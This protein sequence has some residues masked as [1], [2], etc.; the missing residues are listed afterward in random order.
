MDPHKKQLHASLAYQF[1]AAEKEKLEDLAKSI[2]LDLPVRWDLR[3]YSREPR[4]A[5]MQ[6]CCYKVK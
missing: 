3:L 2:R 5:N 1:P 4:V 6:V